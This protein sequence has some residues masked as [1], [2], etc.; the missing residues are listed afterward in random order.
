MAI[1]LPSKVSKSEEFTLNRDS[2]QAAGLKAWYPLGADNSGKDWSGYGNHG[3]KVNA[4]SQ[5]G[6]GSATIPNKTIVP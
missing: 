3:T 4:A 5:G 6:A 1:P 2:W